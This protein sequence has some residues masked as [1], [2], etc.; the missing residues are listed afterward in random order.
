[1]S[2]IVHDQGPNHGKEV[3]WRRVGSFAL[4]DKIRLWLAA[5]EVIVSP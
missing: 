2:V 4:G 5:R 1:L 3:V